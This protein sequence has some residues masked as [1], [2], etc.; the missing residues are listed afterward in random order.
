MKR[1]ESLDNRAEARDADGAGDGWGSLYAPCAEDND[2][3]RAAALELD[4]GPFHQL[5]YLPFFSEQL[6]I[7]TINNTFRSVGQMSGLAVSS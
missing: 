7:R 2:D 5:I 6:T 1:G 4:N 3:R